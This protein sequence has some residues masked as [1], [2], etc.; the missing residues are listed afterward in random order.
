M[1]T[2]LV[3]VI[4]ALVLVLGFLTGI[5]LYK[6]ND[7]GK[8]VQDEGIIASKVDDECTVI[9][10]LEAMGMLDLIMTNAR[11]EKVSPK[12]TLT[13]KKLYTKCN[14]IIEK[15]EK[16][17]VE[18][19]N[20]DKDEFKDRYKDLEIQKFTANEIVL[21]KEVDDFCNEHYSLK[22]VNG[23]IGIYELDKND[24][25]TKLIRV[26]NIATEYLTATDLINIEKGMKVYTNKELNKVLEDFE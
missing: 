18:L 11:D 24:N 8:E 22:D 26:T 1:K 3:I 2:L 20:L 15:S 25:E 6:I 21:Y 10:E 9:S 23:Y 13:I 12:G 4:I 16:V 17:T 7:L 5:Q 19:T 14:H